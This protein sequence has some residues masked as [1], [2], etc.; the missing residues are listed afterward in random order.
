MSNSG[1]TVADILGTGGVRDA[2]GDPIGK[3]GVLNLPSYF[4]L[5]VL[6]A[7]I[8]PIANEQGSYWGTLSYL[9]KS[10]RGSA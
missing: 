3:K 9:K 8:A 1:S 5:S 10:F 2:D 4:L 6:L 7:H